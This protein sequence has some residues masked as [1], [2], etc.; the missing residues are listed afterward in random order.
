MLG[1]SLSGGNVLAGMLALFLLQQFVTEGYVQ[2]SQ[3][4]MVYTRSEPGIENLTM[5]V[6]EMGRYP[7][8]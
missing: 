7:N 8:V 6:R 5:S 3:D 2:P 1:I 4:G